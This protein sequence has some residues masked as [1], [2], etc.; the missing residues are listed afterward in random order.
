MA[1]NLTG[2]RI[3]FLVA[4]EGIEQ[5]E[6]TE[7]RQAAAVAGAA[8]DLVAPKPGEAQAYNHLDKADTFP[9]GRTTNEVHE[10]EYDAVV[11]PGGVANGDQLRTDEPAVRSPVG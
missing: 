8:V 5:V 4:N 3:A 11:L 1:K 7:P 10:S 9:V 2:T 6:Q